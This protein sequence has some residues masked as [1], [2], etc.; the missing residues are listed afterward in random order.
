MA[1]QQSGDVESPS[2][3]SHDFEPKD[4][5]QDVSNFSEVWQF[6]THKLAWMPPWCRWT[7]D[8]PP[9]FS[10]LHNILFA[11]AGA[12]TVANLY[13]NHPILNILAAEFHTD[14]ATISRIPTLMQAGYAVGLLCLC[15]LGDLLR[16]RFLTLTMVFLAATLW[17]APVP[18]CPSLEC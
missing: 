8:K 6:A 10:V 2:R 16:R 5:L 1:Q 7:P 14:Y 13:Y 3:S 18:H 9:V 17:Y 15:P 4:Q 12:F 11:F